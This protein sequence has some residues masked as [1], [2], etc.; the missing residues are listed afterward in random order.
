MDAESVSNMA[1]TPTV[2][3][4]KDL[5]GKL[6]REAYRAFHSIKRIHKEDHFYNFCV[7]AHSMRDYF[8]EYKGIKLT[9]ERDIYHQEW[10]ED[11]F[12]VAA[13]EIVNTWKHFRLRN[14]PKTKEVHQGENV[15]V[16]TYVENNKVSD[17]FVKLP[18]LIVTLASEKEF[19]LHEFTTHVTCYWHKFLSS[20][21]IN[22]QQQ[23]VSELLP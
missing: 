8:F 14:Q 4:I 6:E 21:S 17:K 3:S 11:E 7:T 10:N 5:F 19:A 15:F 1:L 16:E 13:K 18:D 20:K 23:S 12:L 9:T 2:K 22:V